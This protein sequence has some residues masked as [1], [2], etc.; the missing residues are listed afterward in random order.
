[1]RSVPVGAA[2]AAAL[3]LAPGIGA[4]TARSEGIRLYEAREHAAAEAYFEK[5]LAADARDAEA[6]HF[7]GRLAMIDDK[8]RDAARLFERAIAIVPDNSVYQMWLGRA[9]GRQAQRAGALSKMGLAKKTRK[10]MERAVS[11]DGAN[12]EAREDLLQYYAQ[13][14]GIVGGSMEKAFA[15]ASEIER[16]DP[17]RG[18][19]ARASLYE[20]EKKWADAERT[21]TALLRDHPTAPSVELQLGLF[22]ARSEQW[23]KAF[24]HFEGMLRRDPSN[25][26][27]LFQL[28]RTGALSGQRLERAAAALRGYL[29]AGPERGGSLPPPAAAH[30]RLGNVLEQSGDRAAAKAEYEE[31]LRLQPDHR[32]AKE[33]LERVR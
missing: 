2:L 22:Y 18:A 11:L 14:P 9:Y 33:A 13:A 5:A 21:Y 16:L 32:E 1:M 12:I 24:E 31:T 29:E 10:A 25:L 23:E 27:A 8:D 20:R 15:Q 28:G 17:V 7:L 4:Q 19:R 26:S 6:L 3:L 30:F